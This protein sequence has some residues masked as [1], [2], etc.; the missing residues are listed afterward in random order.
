M[1]F[2]LH[3]KDA[4]VDIMEGVRHDAAVFLSATTFYPRPAFLS[5]PSAP[6]WAVLA[7][8]VV[9]DVHE[10]LLALTLSRGGSSPA[11]W[12]NMHRLLWRS[13]QI[14]IASRGFMS[15]PAQ[16]GQAQEYALFLSQ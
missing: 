2:G 7:E 8:E 1:G 15:P 13:L 6:A 11:L 14:T 9:F 4:A 16:G 3:K 10:F 12:R 5:L